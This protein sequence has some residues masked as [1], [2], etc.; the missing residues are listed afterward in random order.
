MKQCYLS[1]NSR[2]HEL[3]EEQER[4]ND[5]LLS[6]TTHFAQVQF[7]LKQ[8][9]QAD[10]R[11]RDNLLK[12]LQEFAFKGCTDINEIK[13]QRK[14]ATLL[15]SSQSD[16]NA[17][18]ADVNKASADSGVKYDDYLKNIGGTTTAI[19]RAK[20]EEVLKE[21]KHK[22]MQL[23]EQ[24]REQLADL[25]KFAYETGDGGI[26]SNEL[27]AKQKAVLDKLHERLQLNLELD[28]MSYSDL[29][30]QVD[31]AVKQLMNPI[32]AK[33]QL[34]E[35]LQTQIVDL[36]RFVSF[37]Q[38]ESGGSSDTDP[39]RSHRRRKSSSSSCMSQID[40]QQHSPISI[41]SMPLAKHNQQHLNKHNL[42]VNLVGCGSKRFERNQ[43][44]GTMRGNHYGDVRAELQLAVDETIK[45]CEKYFLLSV[46]SDYPPRTRTHSIGGSSVDEDIFERS[47]EEVVWI[48]RKEL[49]TALK[50]LLEH[51]MNEF[52]LKLTS[53][54]PPFGCFSSRALHTFSNAGSS[55]NSKG[56]SS[57]SR[58]LEHIWDVVVYYFDLKNAREFSDAPVRKLS[59]S[60]Q[61]DSVAGRTLTSKQMLL[62]TIENILTSHSRLKRSSDAMWKAFVCAALNAKKLP[63]WIRIIFRTR[64]IVESCF[65]SWAY[66][67]R[68]GCEDCYELFES[69]H[70]YHF[71]LPVDLAVRPFHQ[72]KDAF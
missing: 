27:I 19:D 43:L 37:L 49:C 9:L 17:D 35:Q 1:E 3:E 48:V 16:N 18:T 58:K 11:D 50:H 34:V 26:P 57:S 60:F 63:A 23:I 33:Q 41:A 36:E 42:L 4:L 8:V 71:E 51:G 6:L 15:Y 7:R 61:L 62:S 22:Q 40:A 20:S 53:T 24:L 69:L 39:E 44:K 12:E 13:R 66:I 25:E 47:E 68:T 46:D 10:G 72:M 55:S 70:K 64:A 30:K 21:R 28:K 29:Q 2:V 52:V 32:K 67:A 14:S 59:Q 54:F 45:V 31:E 38:V 56:V 5:S 65:H